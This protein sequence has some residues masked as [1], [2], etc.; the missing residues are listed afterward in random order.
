MMLSTL[1]FIQI[2]INQ[3]F[4]PKANNSKN[5][6]P[7][8]KANFITK[9]LQN[10]NFSL[11]YLNLIKIEKNILSH[12]TIKKIFPWLKKFPLII[13]SIKSPK[14][15]LTNLPK[16]LLSKMYKTLQNHLHLIVQKTCS[17]S[18]VNLK[19]KNHFN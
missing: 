8:I 12:Q 5:H 7:K 15:N 10:N 9:S 19:I 11:I 18:N 17:N 6:H 4:R 14:N 2:N 1:S 3:L 13:L 16:S